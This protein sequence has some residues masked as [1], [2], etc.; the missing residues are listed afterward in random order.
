MQR[1]HFISFISLAVSIIAAAASPIVSFFD[2]AF[3]ALLTMADARPALDRIAAAFA[4]EPMPYAYCGHDAPA[5]LRHEA[6]THRRAAAR[7]V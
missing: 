1:R 6:G 7:N 3:T 2:R 4:L 5:S